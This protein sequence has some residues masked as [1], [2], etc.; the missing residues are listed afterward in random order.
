MG[1]LVTVVITTYKRPVSILKRAVDS[2]IKQTYSNIELIVVN[3]FP[4]DKSAAKEIQL[5]LESYQSKK[6]QYL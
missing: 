1:D 2:V 5:M 4:E 3:D 6:I